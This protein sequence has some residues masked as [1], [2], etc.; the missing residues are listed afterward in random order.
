M[1][2]IKFIQSSYVKGHGSHRLFLIKGI[3]INSSEL[4]K[5]QLFFESLQMIEIIRYKMSFLYR[6]IFEI[7]FFPLQFY[8]NFSRHENIEDW[9]DNDF[10]ILYYNKYPE[11]K[12][13]V[14]VYKKQRNTI[15]QYNDFYREKMKNLDQKKS[16]EKSR[17][18]SNYNLVIEQI[19]LLPQ[20][21]NNIKS[22]PGGWKCI[23]II[24]DVTDNLYEN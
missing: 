20:F 12:H 13:I 7:Y 2:D 14:N 9:I 19:S 11:D 21:Y 18:I 24:S 23:D 6:Y 5:D 4:F 15:S 22:F 1:E 3:I 8:N 16:L 10:L 17:N